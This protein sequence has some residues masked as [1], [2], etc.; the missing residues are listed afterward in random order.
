M[1]L[2]VV[3]L[4]FGLKNGAATLPHFWLQPLLG[5]S[6]YYFSNAREKCFC[7]FYS[8]ISSNTKG[9]AARAIFEVDIVNWVAL[10]DRC[11]LDYLVEVSCPFSTNSC[12][13]RELVVQALQC[14]FW[15]PGLVMEITAVRGRASL[16]TC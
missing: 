11:C 7:F 2:V 15:Y 5:H 14:L 4:N 8:V 10:V 3:T 9:T 16:S 13:A 12:F 6:K 1:R